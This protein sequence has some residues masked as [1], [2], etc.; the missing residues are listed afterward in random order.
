MH[1]S[2]FLGMC[3]CGG[4]GDTEITVQQQLGNAVSQ[5]LAKLPSGYKEDHYNAIY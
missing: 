3:V 1:E 2:V 5:W 4:G